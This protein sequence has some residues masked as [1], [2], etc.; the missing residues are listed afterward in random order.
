[1]VAAHDADAHD[2]D[3]QRTVRADYRLTHDPKGSLD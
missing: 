2:P 3:F 1:M